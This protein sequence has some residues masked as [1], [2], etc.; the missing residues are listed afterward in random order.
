MKKIT[1]LKVEKI[2]NRTAPRKLSDSRVTSEYKV[3][4]ESLRQE[5]NKI[6]LKKI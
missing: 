3:L 5:E 1:K 4:V 6:L 2:Q